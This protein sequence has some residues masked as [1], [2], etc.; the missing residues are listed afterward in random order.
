MISKTAVTSL[1]ASMVDLYNKSSARYVA[2][3][4]GLNAN[5]PVF[6]NKYRALGQIAGAL[7]VFTPDDF[8]KLSGNKYFFASPDNYDDNIVNILDKVLS[9]LERNKQLPLK[10]ARN[11]AVAFTELEKLIAYVKTYL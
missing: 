10:N 8:V 1:L 3:E 5:D 9:S 7:S 6:L 11:F 4:L 2:D